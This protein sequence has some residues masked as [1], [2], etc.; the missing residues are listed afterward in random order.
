MGDA[1]VARVVCKVGVITG[2]EPSV[3][4]ET[5]SDARTAPGER[6]APAAPDMA[7]LYQ[8]HHRRVF[9]LALRYSGGRPDFAEDITHDVF[10]I[11]M[12]H[13]PKL[14]DHDDLSSWLYRVT[15]NQ[16][17]KRLRR[18]R[19]RRM[20]VTLG[21]LPQRDDSVRIEE[22]ILAR[23]GLRQAMSALQSLPPKQRIAFAMHTLDGKTMQEIAKILGHSK[24]YISKLVAR[25][26]EKLR[27]EQWE[28]S[29]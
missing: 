28:I 27:K 15:A 11:L 22:A 9:H 24:G 3:L 23:D 2:Q 12:R 26:Q 14:R 18:G 21:L 7:G 13:A 8:Q 19:F 20:V 25:A 6:H 16:C 29:P 1:F 4:G 10:I 17:L 5:S